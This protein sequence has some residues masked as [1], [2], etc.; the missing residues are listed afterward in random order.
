MALQVREKE[1]AYVCYLV[2]LLTPSG[3]GWLPAPI[4]LFI[5]K[6]VWQALP[7]SPGMPR[8]HCP[9]GAQGMAGYDKRRRLQHCLGSDTSGRLYSA[10]LAWPGDTAL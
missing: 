4:I 8:C 1:S 7:C 9:V 6:R 5:P 3:T 2:L 10:Y